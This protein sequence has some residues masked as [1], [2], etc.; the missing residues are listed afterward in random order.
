MDERIRTFLETVQSEEALYAAGPWSAEWRCLAAVTKK[1]NS[2]NKQ[3]SILL[4]I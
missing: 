1:H 4:H 2:V 3:E